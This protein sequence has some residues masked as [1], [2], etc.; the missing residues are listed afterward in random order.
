MNLSSLVLAGVLTGCA[1]ARSVAASE[2]HLDPREALVA[3]REALRA[4]VASSPPPSDDPQCGAAAPMAVKV[5][6]PA[7]ILLVPLLVPM[8]IGSEV[9][10]K[11]NAAAVERLRRLAEI[12]RALAQL[13]AEEQARPTAL[14]LQ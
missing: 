7:A 8:S 5:K 9:C 6:N 10:S 3:E 14:A 2:Q 4:V 12:Q 11:Q 1:T 13:D